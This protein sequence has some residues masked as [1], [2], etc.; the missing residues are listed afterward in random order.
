MIFHRFLL[1][2]GL[3]LGLAAPLAAFSP[4]DCAENYIADDLPPD[5]RATTLPGYFV[6]PGQIGSD[7]ICTLV[8]SEVYGP[9]IQVSEAIPDSP[10]AAFVQYFP[11]TIQI[12]R[13]D[14]DGAGLSLT[15]CGPIRDDLPPDQNPGGFWC[16]IDI[17]VGL[18]VVFDLEYDIEGSLSWLNFEVGA[19]EN[20]ILAGSTLAPVLPDT[21]PGELRAGVILTTDNTTHLLRYVPAPDVFRTVEPGAMLDLYFTQVESPQDMTIVIETGDPET[22]PFAQ[23]DFPAYILEDILAELALVEGLIRTHRGL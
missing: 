12:L 16:R 17:S 14:G 2:Y 10:N 20:S 21:V 1:A 4:S 11:D 7:L 9:V 13:T 18:G 15:A 6:E 8:P 3:I 5:A 22:G 19:G 23:A